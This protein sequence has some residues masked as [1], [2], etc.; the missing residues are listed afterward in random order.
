MHPPEHRIYV[1]ILIGSIVLGCLIILFVVSIATYHIRKVRLHQRGVAITINML[2][3]ERARIAS[4]L[5]DDFGASLS[6]IKVQL[7]CLNMVSNE[8]ALVVKTCERVIDD[9]MNKI[10][11]TSFNLMPP[12]LQRTGLKEALRQFIELMAPPKKIKVNYQFTAGDIEKE[13]SI[14]VYRI[15]QEILN[16]IIKH[17]NASLIN[18]SITKDD[19]CITMHISDNGIGFDKK[20]ASKFPGAGLRNIDTRKDL[21]KAKIYLTTAPGRGTDFIIKIPVK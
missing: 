13:K 4:D 7:H 21:L 19:K 1:A 3:S 6:A 12:A 17:A 15:A 20:L 14:H 11:L 10:R 16:N 9:V 5:H 8:D 2:E 18:F